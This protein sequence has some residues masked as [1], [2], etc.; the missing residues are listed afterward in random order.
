MGRLAV[1]SFFGYAFTTTAA[2]AYIDP[3]TGSMLTTAILGAAAAV[4]FTFRKYMYKL[5]KLVF[6]SSSDK[7]GAPIDKK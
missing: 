4:A 5:R 2:Y 7:D 6:G 1:L 3:G